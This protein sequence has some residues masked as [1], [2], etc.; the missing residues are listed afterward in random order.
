MSIPRE[1]DV[2]TS[3]DGVTS[4]VIEHCNDYDPT[5]QE[6]NDYATWLGIDIEKEPELLYIAREGL[7]APLPEEWKAVQTDQKEIYYF[8][9]SNG[10]SLWD[11]PLDEM[12]KQKVVNA[13]TWLQKEA[14]KRELETSSAKQ[15]EI[16][17]TSSSPSPSAPIFVDAKDSAQRKGK[18]APLEKPAKSS[19]WLPAAGA[20]F[21]SEDGTKSVVLEDIVSGAPVTKEEVKEYAIWLGI[22][23]EN[24]KD[25]LWI[26]EEGLNAPLPQD[27]KPCK[28]DTNEIY[29]FNFRTGESIWD[30]PLDDHY[31]QKLLNERA[32]KQKTGITTA[33]VAATPVAVDVSD[34]DT[35]QRKKKGASQSSEQQQQQQGFRRR[36]L[37]D[38]SL[39]PPAGTKF[40]RPDGVEMEI[41]EDNVL[42]HPSKEEIEEYAGYIGIDVLQEPELLHIAEK[43]ITANLPPYYRACKIV[44]Q[45]DVFYFDFKNMKSY[46]DHPVDEQCKIEVVSAREE[47]LGLRTATEAKVLGDS[48]I[49]A[50]VP[51]E[52]QGKI[53]MS[54]GTQPTTPKRDRRRLYVVGVVG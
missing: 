12:F 42:Q 28:T 49:A 5:P 26:A 44:N 39:P 34:D 4:T 43:G 14:K 19:S 54:K 35:K 7:L 48:T 36:S 16:T 18:V 15:S 40:R 22:D 17:T 6:I 2:F 25:L 9:F 29:Y 47:L 50:P 33:D 11:H 24:E 30:H 21:E 23:Y 46:W 27:W 3:N 1:G 38:V 52:N 10:E 31:K 20:T 51:A 8:N 13:R 32:K 53:A 37:D 45:D 41:L